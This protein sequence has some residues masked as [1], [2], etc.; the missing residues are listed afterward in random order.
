MI[1]RNLTMEIKSWYA[2]HTNPREEDRAHS[3]LSAWG[4]ETCCPKL[5]SV[6]SL[7]FTG[8]TVQVID[9]LFPRYIF[10][11]FN[12]DA[13]L[14][15]VRFTR[16]VRNVVM[17]GDVP[18]RVEDEII[19][20]LRSRMSPDGL[21]T[22]QDEFDEGDEVYL[23]AGPFKGFTGVFN[24]RLT[25]SERVMILLDTVRFQGRLIIDKALIEKR[26]PVVRTGLE[27]AVEEDTAGRCCRRLSA[28]KKVTTLNRRG[29]SV[30][31][32]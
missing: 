24:S 30:S 19:D 22:P 9:H 13:M 32:S 23:K 15:K 6:R 12:A 31:T 4:V 10:A 11:R 28:F 7:N 17:I 1:N 26:P 16:G 14:H 25:G 3:N 20:L 27:D 29:F 2:I 21:I 8:R 5:K 18:A